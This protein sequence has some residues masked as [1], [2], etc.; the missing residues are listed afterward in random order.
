MEEEGELAGL[1]SVFLLVSR[2]A[3]DLLLLKLSI[4]LELFIFFL[5]VQRVCFSTS[6]TLQTASVAGTRQLGEQTVAWQCRGLYPS[7]LFFV[8]L[9]VRT[10]H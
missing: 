3:L 5:E 4:Y 8:Q 2:R 6:K 1:F 10:I 7:L 9:T